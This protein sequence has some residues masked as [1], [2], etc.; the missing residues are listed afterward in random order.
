MARSYQ[1]VKMK[2]N[3]RTLYGVP[4]Y[5]IQR[6]ALLMDEQ[7]LPVQAARMGYDRIY[8]LERIA[9]AHATR[10]QMLRQ[11]ALRLFH[12]YQGTQASAQQRLA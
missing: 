10:S 5:L 2:P 7:G 11:M 6:F 3:D 9:T 8:A 1:T 12:A 4:G